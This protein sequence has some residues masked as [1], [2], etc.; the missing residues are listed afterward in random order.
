MNQYYHQ[1][2]FHVIADVHH[3]MKYARIRVFTDPYSPVYR[4]NPAFCPYTGEY[5]SVKNSILAYFM[6]CIR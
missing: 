6:Q 1:N 4:P 3:C 2:T 5:G